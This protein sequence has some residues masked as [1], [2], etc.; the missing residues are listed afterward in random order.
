VQASRDLVGILIE[1]AA[2]MQLGHHDLGCR[3]LLFVVF[4]DVGRDSAAVVEH[5][6]RVVG[7]NHDLDLVAVACQCLVDGVIQHFEHHVMQAGAV[8]GVADVHARPLAHGVEALQDLDA[9]GVVAAVTVTV[10][11]LGVRFVHSVFLYCRSP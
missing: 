9:G 5:G 2:G 1:L 6:D 8:G 10:D 4:L 3:A 11:G 7:V